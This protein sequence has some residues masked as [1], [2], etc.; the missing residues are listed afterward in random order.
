MII[1][2]TVSV[3]KPVIA[4]NNG[5]KDR[6]KGLSVLIIVK[7]FSPRIAPGCYMID[8]TWV[9]DSQRSG[10]VNTLTEIILYFKT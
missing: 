4:F 9:F 3:A 2:E 8:G 5:S 6:E 1:H 10:H 7:N